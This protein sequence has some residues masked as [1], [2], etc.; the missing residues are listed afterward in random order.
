MTSDEGSDKVIAG[1]EAANTDT[2]IYTGFISNEGFDLVVHQ[3]PSTKN[4]N[5]LVLLVT[6]GGNP[7][8]AFRI[9]RFLRRSYEKVT[10][11]VPSLCKSART[12]ICIGAHEIVISD[13]GELGPLDVQ[14]REQNELFTSRSGLA[15]PEALD[16]LESR[17]INSL[18]SVLV[19]VAGGGGLGTKRAS[20]IAVN[21]TV[22]VFAPIYSKIDPAGLGETARALA[23]AQDYA[24]R[25]PGNLRPGALERLVTGYSSHSFVID[26]EETRE[27]FLNVR[28]PEEYEATIVE[29]LGLLST[30]R[31]IQDSRLNVCYITSETDEGA[32]RGENGS[33]QGTD[34]Q[35]PTGTVGSSEGNR[36]RD[37][38][39][40]SDAAKA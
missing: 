10:V 11:Y 5:I 23:V 33:G 17:M 24:T 1:L 38:S 20:Q 35:D 13:T 12:L 6:L 7:D 30:E 8:A 32:S 29:H 26:S 27:L 28:A 15:I 31:A 39:E 34:S 3:A 2:L 21:A 9:V 25:L 14:V 19:D 18:R 4:K 36:P 22:G 16:F 40:G 37:V